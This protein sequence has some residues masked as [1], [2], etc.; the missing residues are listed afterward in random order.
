M[1]DN[2]SF[3]F[4]VTRNDNKIN[5]SFNCDSSGVVYLFNF[6]VCGVQYESSTSTPFR[7]RF[8]NYRACYRRFWSGF[9]VPQMDFFRHLSKEGHH[10]LV[11]DIRVAII[12]K[13][14]GEC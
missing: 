11:E 5:F 3:F 6:F 13:P 10:G 7:L 4:H 2:N 14:I 12:D 1:S 8:N 9:S